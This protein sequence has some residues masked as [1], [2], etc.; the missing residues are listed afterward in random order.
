MK[1][2]HG[3][4]IPVR[5]LSESLSVQ[6]IPNSAVCFPCINSLSQ[7]LK[8]LR[9]FQ[10]MCLT[11][12]CPD[13]PRKRYDYIQQLKRGLNVPV[14]LLTYS[15]GNN[16]GNLHFIWRYDGDTKLETV[17]QDS[18]PVVETIK[19]HIPTYHTRAMRRALFTKFGRVSSSVKPAILRYFYR[20]L[21]GDSSAASNLCEAEMDQRVHQ[22]LDR[23]RIRRPLLTFA[24]SIPL[25]RE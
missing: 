14:V 9:P 19:P 15:P 2:V 7:S 18:L 10:Y 3:S 8:Q 5:E 13:E 16:R 17:F 11:E 1:A 12:H 22:L 25:Q 24:V 4:E 21:T 20:D 23:K 6:V